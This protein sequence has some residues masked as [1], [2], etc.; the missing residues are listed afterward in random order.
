MIENFS[1]LRER[2]IYIDN[3]LTGQVF[4]TSNSQSNY[5]GLFILYFQIV[6]GFS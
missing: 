2:I 1:S 5:L 6:I 3:N 4:V